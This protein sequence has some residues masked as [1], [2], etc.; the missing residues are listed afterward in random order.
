MNRGIY[1]TI[2]VAFVL[3]I[4]LVLLLSAL[5]SVDETEY[6]LELR[7]GEVRNVRT[8]PGLYV[9]APVDRLGATYRQAYPTG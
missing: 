4:G 6:G 1:M 8:E 7:F 3:L 2:G 5:Y 9:K